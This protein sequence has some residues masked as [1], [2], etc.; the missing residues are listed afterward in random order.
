MT[1]R[2]DR[3]SA[4]TAALWFRARKAKATALISSDASDRTGMAATIA[5]G[6]TP[7][8]TLKVSAD[9]SFRTTIRRIATPAIAEARTASAD[10]PPTRLRTERADRPVEGLA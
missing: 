1:L 4:K 8:Q 5:M 10:V 3:T 6:R 7:N 9:P 2:R